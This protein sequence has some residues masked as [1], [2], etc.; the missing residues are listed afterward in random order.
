MLSTATSL[1]NW[2]LRGTQA[3]IHSPNIPG[4]PPKAR[5]AVVRLQPDG[6]RRVQAP[7]VS[8]GEHRPFPGFPARHGATQQLDLVGGWATPLKKMKVN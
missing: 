8:P 7:P 6:Q 4:S 2:A 3:P 5:N 1:K